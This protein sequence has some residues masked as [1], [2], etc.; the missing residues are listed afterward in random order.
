MNRTDIKG[1]FHYDSLDKISDGTYVSYTNDRLVFYFNDSTG[2]T[3]TGYVRFV[4]FIIVFVDII[5]Y[6]LDAPS[7]SFVSISASSHYHEVDLVLC[8]FT[9]LMGEL[10][11]RHSLESAAARNLRC[12]APNGFLRKY[13]SVQGEQHIASVS[14]RI[15]LGYSLEW[16]QNVSS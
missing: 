2:H 12:R 9:Q 13:E 15:E 6:H 4:P 3:F 5:W 10:I 1:H 11:A 7:S 14:T 16:N 8:L